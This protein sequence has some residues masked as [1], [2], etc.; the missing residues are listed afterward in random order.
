MARSEYRFGLRLRRD[1]EAAGLTVRQLA[2]AADINYSY[3]TKIEKSSSKTGISRSVVR[4]LAV[5]LDADEFEYLHLSGLVPEPL[6][7][8]LATSE[9]REFL[10]EVTSQDLSSQDWQALCRQIR[11]RTAA[12]KPRKRRIA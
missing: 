9:S 6:D 7:A 8:L 1:R 5:A 11:R 4:S 10:R 2:S 12:T 3:I